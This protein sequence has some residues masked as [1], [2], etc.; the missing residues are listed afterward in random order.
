MS[1]IMIELPFELKELG[2][3]LRALVTLTVQQRALAQLPGGQTMDYPSFERALGVAAADVERFAHQAVLQALDIDRPA[4]EIEGQRYTRVGRHQATYYTM[5]GPVPVWRTLYRP[6]AIRNGPTVDA[7]SLRAGVVGAGWLPATAR[8]MAHA[9]QQQPAREAERHAAET[10]RLPYSRSAFEDVTHTL[11]AQFVAQHARVE[12]ALIRAFELPAAA[13]SIS[14]SLD[15]GSLPMVEPRKRPRGRP[16]RNAPKHPKERVFRMGY[17][18]T[19]TLHDATGEALHTLRYGGMPLR[20]GDDLCLGLAG[21]VAE[22]LRRNP[23]LHVVLLCDGAPEMWNLLD[24]QLNPERLG[25][26]VHR[27]VDLWHLLEKLGHAAAALRTS[28]EHRAELLHRWRLRLLNSSS[29]ATAI[30]SEL[31]RSKLEYLR[32]GDSRPVHEAIT[33]LDNHE[34]MF[35]YAGARQHGLPV[36]SGNVEATV[37]SLF[38]VRMKRPGSGWKEDTGEHIVHLRALALSDRWGAG[39]DLTLLPLAKTV[40]PAA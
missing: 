13:T 25:V 8:A 1:S 27:L 18:G 39:I 2:D 21:D 14:V 11:G 10:G 15:R 4:V 22:L 35:D 23:A 20:G 26:K 17:C 33:Y 16:R 40:R 24:A 9:V 34:G 6:D 29:A 12:A 19:V 5:A 36:G 37:K 3:A 38:E 7:V 28:A 30:R 32:I 31:K